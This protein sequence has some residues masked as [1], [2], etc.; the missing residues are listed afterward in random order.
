ME[1][2]STLP[3]AL[4]SLYVGDLHPDITDGQLFDAFSEF[5][6]LATV[7]VCRD[8][9]SGRSLCYGY[10][11]F[12]DPQDAIRAIEIKNHAVV[13]GKIIRVTWSNRDSDARKNGLGNVFVKNLC[14]SIDN[15]KLQEIFTK[16]GT[17][18]SCKVATTEDGKS[19]GYGFV[20]FAAEDS[21]NDAIKKLNGATIEGKQIYVGKFVK[22]SDRIS[23]NP[24]VKYTNLYMK[25]LDS[26]LTEEVLKEKF[27][28]FGK[29]VS[30]IIAKNDYG[31]SKGFGF[32]NFENPDAARLA[33][34]AM[35]GAHIGYM[36]HGKPLYVAI[37]QRKEDRHAL[38]LRQ[39]ARHIAGLAAPPTPVVPGGY[40]PI[41]YPAPGFVPQIPARPPMLMPP[42][43]GWG[44]GGFAHAIR[45][46]GWGPGG[47]APATRTAAFQPPPVPLIPTDARQNRQNGW[48]M[49]NG[50]TLP[51]N[52]GTNRSVAA[53]RESTHRQGSNV[54]IKNIN[55]DVKDE[56][57]R[58]LFSQCGRI[59][60]EKLM[61]D[62]KGTSKGFGF[63]CYSAPEEASK[64]VTTFHGFMFHGKPLY[65]AIAQRKEDR[66]A[67]LLRQHARHIAGLAAPP[68]PVVPGGYP[69]I[70]YPAPGFVPQIPARPPC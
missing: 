32:V 69:P 52:G 2:A 66:H 29:I 12:A 21:A 40:P 27:S 58:E 10:V 9:S 67:Q 8:S 48:G 44:P 6:S 24:D 35:N 23:A 43:V 57:L 70:H 5:K 20:Q 1:V 53:S 30:L 15:V 7:R 14:D 22:K 63:V 45:P 68:T 39:H 25:N 33:V 61:R 3:A 36:F 54:Y 19:K 59:T 37:A 28:L 65:V 50:H 47:L 38:L 56:E 18:S 26:D 51:Q 60:S 55:D 34:E 41:H 64:A 17:I 31:T 49:M 11:N 62:D 13:N 46:V 4:S 42:P 16:F